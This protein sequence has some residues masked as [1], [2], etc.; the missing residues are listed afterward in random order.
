MVRGAAVK[1]ANPPRSGAKARVFV[2]TFSSFDDL[3]ARQRRDPD[4]VLSVLA[5]A[6][7]FSCFEMSEHCRTLWPTVLGLE[8]DGLIEILPAGYP[9]TRVDLTDKGCQRLI[10]IGAQS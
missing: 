1:R 9:W 6:G 3:K 4:V 7:R 8:R 10:D 5:R 2:D